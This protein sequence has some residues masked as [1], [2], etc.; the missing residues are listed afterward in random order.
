MSAAILI[1]ITLSQLM[2]TPSASILTEIINDVTLF[3]NELNTFM[4][5]DGNTTARS[6]SGEFVRPPKVVDTTIIKTKLHELQN[7]VT[8]LA[9]A[10]SNKNQ[11]EDDIKNTIFSLEKQIEDL[12]KQNDDKDREIAQTLEIFE[13][14]ISDLLAKYNNREQYEEFLEAI[15]HKYYQLAA[16]KFATMKNETRAIKFVGRSYEQ[17]DD[18]PSM[19][20]FADKVDDLKRQLLIYKTIIKSNTFG[21]CYDC[22]ILITCRKLMDFRRNNAFNAELS[23]IFSETYYKLILPDCWALRQRFK[24]MK[25]YE[26]KL[27]GKI[28]CS[29]ERYLGPL[30]KSAIQDYCYPIDSICS[31]LL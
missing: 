22:N 29:T 25:K 4:A 8:K 9:E 1:V 27:V 23:E 21:N 14:I 6:A 30:A 7:N 12:I 10:I 26:E 18:L 15:K 5:K 31:I 13:N 16:D 11:N 20:E 3:K 24:T 17:L 28:V 2:L 19:L